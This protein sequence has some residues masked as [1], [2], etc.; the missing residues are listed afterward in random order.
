MVLVSSFLPWPVAFISFNESIVDWGGA[1]LPRQLDLLPVLFR[2]QL[3]ALLSG[4]GLWWRAVS[5]PCDLRK[6]LMILTLQTSNDS[7]NGQFL[8]AQG[9]RDL[10]R[11]I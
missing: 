1:L 8:G 4:P 6:A 11:Q 9:W 3:D 5:M 2:Y 10:K 7:Q